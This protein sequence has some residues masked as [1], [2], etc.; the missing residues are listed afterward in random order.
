MRIPG[1]TRVSSNSPE[2]L[3]ALEQHKARLKA[4]GC[5]EIYWDVASRS[6]DDREGLNTVLKLIE[7]QE[8]DQAVFIR[9]DRMTDSPTVL[10]KAITTCLKANIPIKGLD[11]SIDFTTVGGRLHARLLCNLARAE[12]ERLAER[13]KHGHEHHRK[14]NAAYFAPFGYKK[15]GQRLEL[16]PEPFVCLLN[17]KEELSQAAIGYELVEIYLNTRSIRATLRFFN[18]KYGIHTFS[19][20]SRKYRRHASCLGFSLSGLTAW[21]N[22][23][24]LRGHT[25]YGRAYKQRNSHKHL[26]DI[27]YNTHPEHRLMSEEEYQAVDSTLDWNAKH[28]SWQ[29]PSSYRIHPLS[30]L[31]RC[32]ECRG[33]C[34]TVGFKLRT[35]PNVKKHNYQCSNYHTKSCDQKK[36]L[37]DEIIEQSVIQSLAKRAETLTAIAE[38]PPD[39][40]DPPELQELKAELSF[41]ENAPGSRAAG[42]VAELRHQIEDYYSR[43]QEGQQQVSTQRDLLLQVFSDRSYWK[44][45]LPEERRDL[46]RALV[47][48]VSIRAGQVEAVL[49]KV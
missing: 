33:F 41:Y 7:R 38:L 48:Q 6:R 5:T 35:D 12:V 31:V 17:T 42:I 37:R 30:G 32:A 47:D 46:Y 25:A 43:Q 9:V 21:L 49:L 16:N 39:N 8:C 45:L 29:P 1:Y 14:M 40:V 11:D 19:G 2:Q 10:E 15:V 26:W 4:A 18:D 36:S 23:P 13:V 44:T 34:K 20:K 28:R 22:N 3:K 27:R 24:I